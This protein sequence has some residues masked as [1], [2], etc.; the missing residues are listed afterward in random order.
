M[1]HVS[2]RYAEHIVSW[3]YNAEPV[4]VTSD[5]IRGRYSLNWDC[6][7]FWE[8]PCDVEG[9]PMV[10]LAVVAPFVFIAGTSRESLCDTRYMAQSMKIANAFSHG[11]VYPRH[12]VLHYYVFTVSRMLL[13]LLLC[14]KRLQLRICINHVIALLSLN[15]L[16]R[17]SHP[18][19]I[20]CADSLHPTNLPCESAA[21]S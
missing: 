4:K 21:D 6:R 9:S 14:S 1:G 19:P 11:G 12:G 13:G 8:T 2:Y 18:R 17:N 5:L 10:V 3:A 15:L 7:N 20:C 16:P